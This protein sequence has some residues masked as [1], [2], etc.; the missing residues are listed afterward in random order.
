MVGSTESILDDMNDLV[1]CNIQVSVCHETSRST[2]AGSTHIQKLGTSIVKA[3][4]FARAVDV[5]VYDKLWMIFDQNDKRYV[6][7]FGA[8]YTA[9]RW[10]DHW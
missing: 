7:L 5:R 6:T 1:S 2:Q 4:I 9:C 8:Y 3:S 10:W